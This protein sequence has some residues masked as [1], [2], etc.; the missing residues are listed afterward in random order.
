MR[1]ENSIRNSAFAVGGQMIGIV[2]GF[3]MRTVFINILGDDYLGLNG[4]FESVLSLLSLTELGIGT[5]ITFALYEPIARCEY[6][7]IGA[8]M[9]FF[10]RVYRAVAAVTAVLGLCLMPFLDRIT[11]DLSGQIPGV[12]TI[13]LLF[14]SNTVISYFFSYQR[15]LITAY[16][17]HYVNILNDSIFLLAKYAIQIIVLIVWRNYI[18][19]LAIQ[20]IA[21]LASNLAIAHRYNRMFPFIREY[22]SERLD[23]QAL[24][25]I[26]KN[27]A[28]MLYHRAS[29]IVV[30]GTD[31]L[32]ISRISLQLI[33]LYSNYLMIISAV[34]TVLSQMFSAATASLGNLVATEGRERQHEVYEKIVFLNFWLFGL[35]AAFLGSVVEPF[36]ALW[37]TRQRLLPTSALMLML[38]NFYLNGMRLS[39]HMVIN[40]SG[41]FSKLRLKSV[42]EAII[43]LVFSLAFMVVFDMGLYGVLAGTTLSVVS[44]N[45]WWE[46]YVVYKYAF[47][48]R[49]A[50]YFVRYAKY[51]AVSALALFLTRYACSFIHADH[52]GGLILICTVA[53]LLPNALFGVCFWRTAE[54]RFLTHTCAKVIFRLLHLRRR[55]ALN[56]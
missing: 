4:L 8:L 14:L 48:R 29:G 3:A 39:N 15:I 13:Y 7:R 37:V 1:T 23:Q 53:F 12:Q 25:A 46:S 55:G 33:G 49:P 27:V 26:K 24:K 2:T 41:L 6:A 43:N 20:L 34:S 56:A 30:T 44:T 54:F 16:E 47:S 35:C 32:L 9:R 31:N 50:R 36:I 19:Y 17:R 22:R 28:A 52:W 11:G 5:A 10:A 51:A 45:L 42:L 38:L 18:A 21:A 40:A